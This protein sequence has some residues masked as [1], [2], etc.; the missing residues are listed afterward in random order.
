MKAAA[1]KQI[2]NSFLLN[3]RTKIPQNFRADSVAGRL[4]LGADEMSF[5]WLVIAA[6]HD[7]L[8]APH[9]VVFNRAHG[10]DLPFLAH[11]ADGM[12]GKGR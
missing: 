8:T 5:V 11:A 10:L 6:G 12:P 7:P 3:M 4:G 9:V 2:D 1:A